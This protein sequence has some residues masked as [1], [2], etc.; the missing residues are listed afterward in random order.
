[1]LA[2]WLDAEREAEA[3][4]TV[5]GVQPV[6][7][8]AVADERPELITKVISAGNS[9]SRINIAWRRTAPTVWPRSDGTS[10]RTRCRMSP[11]GDYCVGICVA[12][13]PSGIGDTGKKFLI[14]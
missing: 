2:D 9:F 3:A 1:M 10:S 5:T 11:Q 12:Q 4:T 8:V 13:R 6:T 7:S 14:H